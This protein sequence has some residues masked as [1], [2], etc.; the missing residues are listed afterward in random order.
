MTPD[1]LRAVG[2][3][4][5]LCWLLLPAVGLPLSWIAQRRGHR[6]FLARLVPWFVVVP[7]FLLPAYSGAGVFFTLLCAACAASAWELANLGPVAG[8]AG[9]TVALAAATLIVPV[10]TWI[11]AD[12]GAWPTLA[13]ML[14][15]VA[16]WLTA[17]RREAAWPMV[18]LAA[19]LGAA[20]AFW[21]RLER[22]V[23]GFRFVAWVF[24]VVTVND[25]FGFVAGRLAPLGRP[26]PNLSPAK[27]WS[28]YAGGMAAAVLIGQLSAFCLPEVGRARLGW[29]AALVAVGG[30][31]GDL[32]ASA[33]KRRSGVKDFSHALGPMGGVLDRFDSLLGAGWVFSLL[34]F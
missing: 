23:D 13:I 19:A 34:V 12:P 20:A 32:V 30:S 31:A 6:G 10:W 7:M 22:P 5:F 11:G 28:G 14:I 21:I 4:V 25:I 26:W 29:M 24:S 27:T 33:V 9:R 16:A 15:G 2:W 1:A 8:R 18:A 17:G 3:S